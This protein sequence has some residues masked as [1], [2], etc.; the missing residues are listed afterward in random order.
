MGKSEN[1]VKIYYPKEV[2]LE[3]VSFEVNMGS[4]NMEEAQVSSI[5]IECNMGNINVKKCIFEELFIEADMGNVNLE[6]IVTNTIDVTADMGNVD[7]KSID[8][9]EK[10]IVECNMGNVEMSF[11]KPVESYQIYAKINMGELSVDGKKCD[12]SYKTEGEIPLEVSND[13]GNIEL[14]FSKE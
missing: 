4:L 13:M 2:V 5:E 3:D 8:L 6:N 1:K 9:T 7:M 14:D 12:S 11:K 10:G